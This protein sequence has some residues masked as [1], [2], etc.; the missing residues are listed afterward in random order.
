[1]T[2]P[3]EEAELKLLAHLSEDAEHAGGNHQ[4]LWL[5]PKP[6][7][8][9]LGLS[10][11]QFATDSGRLVAHGLAGVRKFASDAVSDTASPYC[12]IW[13]TGKGED[14]MRALRAVLG[15]V[16]KLT[17]DAT[18]E[19]WAKELWAKGAGAVV[20]TAS[21]LLGEFTDHAAPRPTV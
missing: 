14:Y 8:R 19:L 6:L 1:M 15:V 20:G 21:Q 10:Q 2:S 18:K 13:L 16:P 11:E 3:L 4:R 7:I 17:A 12:A 9:R 5:D